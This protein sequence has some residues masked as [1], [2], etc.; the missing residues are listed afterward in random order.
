ME[1]AMTLTRWIYLRAYSLA[2]AVILAAP[3]GPNSAAPASAQSY[4]SH[5]VTIVVPFPAGGPLDSTAR[6]LAD[7]LSASLKQPFIIENRAGAAGNIGTAAVAKAAPDGHTLLVVLDT[8]L[9]ANPALYPKLPFDPESDFAPISIVASFSQML[10]VH[11]SIPVKSLMDFVR[12]AKQNSVTFGSGGAKGN[13]GY[14]TLESLRAEAGFEV[15]HVGYKG[16]T[17]VVSDLVGGHV[18]AGFLS[19]PSVIELVSKGKLNGLA[20]SS[21]RRAQGAPDVPTVSEAGYPGFDVAFSIVVLV[22]AKTPAP[23][24][25]VLESEVLHALRSSDVQAR[26][27]AQELE[28]AGTTGAEAQN[29]LRTTAA[30]WKKVVQAARIQLD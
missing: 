27:R 7:K 26:L 15:V 24:R 6:L 1:A 21:P 10:V 13:P 11:P 18:Q 28:P 14:L 30:R 22:P 4:P 20:V 12:F 5:A 19:T 8:P 9:T 25:A 29:W 3:L 23:I 16:N 17:Q 2:L